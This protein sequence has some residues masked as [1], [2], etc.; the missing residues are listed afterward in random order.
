MWL[1]MIQ[2]ETGLLIALLREAAEQ[3]RAL[4]AERKAVVEGG[5]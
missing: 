2:R 1:D 4:N 3:R 5:G